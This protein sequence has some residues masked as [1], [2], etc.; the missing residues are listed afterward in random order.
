MDPQVQQRAEDRAAR[1]RALR[2]GRITVYR[3][4]LAKQRQGALLPR[5]AVAL[6]GLRE[7]LR[8][9]GGIPADEGSPATPSTE[10]LE[11]RG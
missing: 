3:E 1:A 6:E 10:E 2:P 9:S 7:F 5:D 8:I 11:D 4:L